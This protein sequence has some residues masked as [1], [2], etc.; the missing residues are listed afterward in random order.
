[1]ELAQ[2]VCLL[3][4]LHRAVPSASLDKKRIIEL[5]LKNTD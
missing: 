2:C 4:R 1:M 3:L 5:L